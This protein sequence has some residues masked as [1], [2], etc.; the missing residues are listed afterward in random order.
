MLDCL[1]IDAIAPAAHHIVVR[2]PQG[3]YPIHAGEGLLNRAGPLLAHH[4]IAP[5]RIAVVTNTAVAEKHYARLEESL[6][7][8]GY[9]PAVALVQDGERHKTLATVQQLYDEFL[10]ARLDRRG[11]VIAL[12][13]GV[14]GDAAGFAAATYLR[15]V[16]FVQAPTTLLSMV[17]A[18]VGGKTGVDLPQGKNLVGAFKQPEVVLVDTATLATLPA[19]EFRSGLAEVVKHG[20]IGDPDL[21][22]Q[23]EHIG[24]SNLTQMVVDAV[25]VKVQVV[26]EDPF[27]QGRR[28]V[29]NLGHTFG[30]AIELENHFAIR[31]GEAVA[32]GLVAAANLAAEMGECDAD[33]AA[34]IQAVVARLGLPVNVRGQQPDRLLAAMGHDKKRA[35]KVLR[36][37]VPRALGDVTVVDSPGDEVIL[38]VLRG[39]IV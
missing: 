5:G 6:R 25:R 31:H 36:Y 18:S 3:A 32:I 14:V 28:A 30:H 38:R 29:L 27:E 4:G 16:P 15:G 21:F 2:H 35:G 1:A 12:G 10:S 33:L 11:A 34:R 9:L 39:V 24:P 20:I 13:G 22:A 26:E 7:E 19:A 17:D 37:V 8:A 23:L